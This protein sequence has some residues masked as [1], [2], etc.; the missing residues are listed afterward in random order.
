[1]ANG[2]RPQG[3]RP[4]GEPLQVVELVAGSACYPGDFVAMAN[5]GM[6]DPVAAGA[7]ILGL[8][9]TYASGSGVSVLVSIDPNQLYIGQADET[10]IDAQTDIG[11]LCDVVATAGNSTYKI[12]RQEIDSSTIGTGSGGQLVILGVDSRPDN[13]LGTNADVI[14]KINENQAFGETDFAGI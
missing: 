8:C 11:N 14:V 5:D 3:F 7:D 13:A 6:V 10:E 12:S 9:L 1:M 4:K 2:D